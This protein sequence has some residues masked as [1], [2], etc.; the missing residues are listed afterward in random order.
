MADERTHL[1]RR[2][3]NID[4]YHTPQE[5][6]AI[7]IECLSFPVAKL[8]EHVTPHWLS[9]LSNPSQTDAT[10]HFR[11]RDPL[12]GCLFKS[13]LRSQLRI[14]WLKTLKYDKQG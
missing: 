7:T 1:K 2:S 8:N 12:F 13:E 4:S 6:C 14:L 11:T 10:Q 9:L 3:Q 5:G